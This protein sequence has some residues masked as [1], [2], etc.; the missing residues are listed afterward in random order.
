MNHHAWTAITNKIHGYAFYVVISDVEDTNK[1]MLCSITNRKS[2]T[3]VCKLRVKE[4]GII[5]TIL[6]F[7]EF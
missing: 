7:I 2:I 4:Y 6:M 1:A 5:A 3:L